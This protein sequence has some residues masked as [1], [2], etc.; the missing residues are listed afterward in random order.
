[1]PWSGYGRTHWLSDQHFEA[2][3]EYP[4]GSGTPLLGVQFG[5]LLQC[6]GERSKAFPKCHPLLVC[7][8]PSPPRK[9]GG[10]GTG[11][12]REAPQFPFVGDAE[13]FH[14]IEGTK[15]AGPAPCQ[16]NY[17]ARFLSSMS[18]AS[19]LHGVP[20]LRPVRLQSSLSNAMYPRRQ[21]RPPSSHSARW[22][23]GLPLFLRQQGIQQQI[24][25]G[26]QNDL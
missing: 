13:P 8:G 10:D 1:M 2:C 12:A 16:A 21:S 20:L 18:A 5:A 4:C 23:A 6:C 11:L 7:P 26:G 17:L 14:G 19:R 24:D 25:G 22:R 15:A 9:P 3:V